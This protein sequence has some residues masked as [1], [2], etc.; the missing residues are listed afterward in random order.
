M[1]SVLLTLCLC[2]EATN[3]APLSLTELISRARENDLRV[4]E[5]EAQLHVLQAKYKQARWAWFPKIDSYF[6][7]GGPTPEAR[8]D[9][10]GG[11]PTTPATIMYDT[12]FGTPGVSFRAEATTV[13][14]IYTFGKLDALEEAGKHGVKVGEA[15]RERAR[16]ESELQLVQAYWGLQLARGGR[17]ALDETMGQ[18]DDAI[19]TLEK[20]RAQQ[21]EQ[22]T[23]MDVYKLAF[24]AEQAK[25]R[26][27]A[28]DSGEGLANAAI[29][30]IVALPKVEV[31]AVELPEPKGEPPA[32]P[33]LLEQ[34]SLRR[35]EMRAMQAGLSAREKEVLIRER[36]FFPDFGLLGFARW[37]YTTSSTRQLSPFAYD[38]YNDASAGVAL[39]MR[40]TW[41]LPQKSA[42]LDEARAELE[43]LQRQK[44]LLEAGIALEIQKA[45]GE[46]ADALLRAKAQTDAERNARRWATAA[47]AA[48]DLGTSDTRELTDAFTALALSTSEKLKAWHDVQLSLAALKKAAGTPVSLLEAAEPRPSPALTPPAK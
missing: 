30:L 15:L 44:E 6:A 40:Y 41:D 46:L 10:L 4:K 9:G 22:V 7:M 12:N 45:H 43:K 13:L 20:L 32:L 8:N 33:A 28:A 14:P 23:Q 19:K 34:A 47:Y 29:A 39:V 37:M 31:E 17:K 11:P 2:A 24:Y 38:P 16:D 26:R 18:L 1:R 21:S 35:P 42:Q 5:S 27:G 25:A 48:F 36:M 3:A